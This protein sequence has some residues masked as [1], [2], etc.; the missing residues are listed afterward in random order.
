MKALLKPEKFEEMQK[1]TT[2]F[3]NGLSNFIQV[4]S[5]PYT[6]NPQ[7]YTQRF[8]GQLACA[9]VPL[10]P[11]LCAC[12]PSSLLVVAELCI[13]VKSD[14]YIGKRDLLYRQKRL[15]DTGIPERVRVVAGGH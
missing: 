13:S 4:H 9:R 3:G 5:K 7:P 8:L 6:L 1:L 10:P 15:T 12:A 14:Q 2:S 11:S